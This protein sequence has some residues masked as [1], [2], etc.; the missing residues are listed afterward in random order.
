MNLSIGK[1]ILNPSSGEVTDGG[2]TRQLTPKS[3]ALLCVLAARPGELISKEELFRV[4]WAGTVV[5]DSALTSCVR[6]LREVLGDDAKQPSYIETHYRRGYRCVA[7]VGKASAGADISVDAPALFGREPELSAL[8]S[9]MARVRAGERQVVFITGDP[10]IG[11]STLAESF[12]ASLP[13]PE[14][15]CSRGQCIEHHGPAEAYLPVLEALDRLCRSVAG[16]LAKQ[17]LAR[18]APGW[19]V[20]MPGLLSN[21][22]LRGVAQRSGAANPQRLLREL[23][24]AIEELARRAP[25]VLLFED[26]HWSDNATL[27]WL[28]HV[29][30]RREPAQ[31]M[32][33]AT[34]RRVEALMRDH[35]LISVHAELSSQGRAH[36]VA[37]GP[38]DAVAMAKLMAGKFDD[39]DAI[40]AV[41]QRVHARTEGHPLFALNLIS[42]LV[43][44]G[45]LQRC[46]EAWQYSAGLEAVDSLLPHDVRH[47]IE[48]R[49][50]RLSLDEQRLLQFASV[51]GQQFSAASVAAGADLPVRDVE[52]AL[53]MLAR[54]D[55]FIRAAELTDGSDRR[56]SARFMFHHALYREVLYEQMPVANRS[57]AHR[58][59]GEHLEQLFG[60]RADDIATELAV[61]FEQGWANERAI[62]WRRRA[63]HNAVR[64]GAP[65]EAIA[66]LNQARKL[67]PGLPP[68]ERA[69]KEVEVCIALGGQFMA[70]LGWAAPEV[71]RAYSQAQRLAEQLPQRQGLFAALWG[72]WLYR[73][74]Q[75]EL[76]Q[77]QS[78][79]DTLLSIGRDQEDASI[80]LQ[81]HHAAWATALARGEL[82]SCCEQAREGAAL[83]LPDRHHCLSEEY[84]GHD[85]GVCARCF[86]SL[87]LA[88]RGERDAARE[89][90][91]SAIALAETL[92]HPFSSAF[93]WYFSSSL[94]QLLDDVEGAASSA[95]TAIRLAREQGFA[96][97]E[98]WASCIAAWA[99]A[100]RTRSEAAIGTLEDNVRLAH[101]AGTSLFQ[102]YLLGLLAEARMCVGDA[103][104]AREAIERAISTARRSGEKFFLARLLCLHAELSDSGP[105]REALAEALGIARAQGARLFE[106]QAG[107]LLATRARPSG[108]T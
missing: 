1:W 4:V 22:E 97:I 18:H 76:D 13:V 17:A 48:H 50:R 74:G 101:E 41:A 46:G 104:R 94:H 9:V 40:R 23:T 98:A 39:G 3:T 26:L 87:A 8:Q 78:L 92:G 33:I 77:A 108:S 42:E 53:Q 12:L 58:R 84:G 20:Q 57:E 73:S 32:V 38:L 71:E 75:G 102:S 35:P 6:E 24:E 43:S 68:G 85:A 25:L 54:S 95:A 56:R 16:G 67:L 100:K 79:C 55:A 19:L 93:A 29:A 47:V 10:G 89:S 5:S 70:A 69:A 80:R 62:H 28:T 2:A 34:Y 11:K 30:R 105:A 31:L 81:A 99:Q 59:I 45:M 27:N 51:A 60:T 83:Y 96:L 52:H 72:L 64:R 91:G 21:T 90:I 37:L 44:R 107:V 15:S 63:A 82:T 88:I 14:V 36:E 66:H 106:E 103:D 61:H 7:P 65:R 49:V 86:H